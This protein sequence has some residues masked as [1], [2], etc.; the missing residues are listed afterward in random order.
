MSSLHK[1]SDFEALCLNNEQSP[2]IY[3][4]IMCLIMLIF[5]INLTLNSIHHFCATVPFSSKTKLYFLIKTYV[6][7]EVNL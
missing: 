6:F 1:N 2:S 7:K 5:S 4:A 3:F